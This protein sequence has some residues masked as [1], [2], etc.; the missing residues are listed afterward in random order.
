MWHLGYFIWNGQIR[1]FWYG[2]WEL[3]VTK[4]PALKA[5]EEKEVQAEGTASAKAPRQEQ[6]RHVEGAEIWAGVE[7]W[8]LA[9]EGCWVNQRPREASGFKL[10]TSLIF[11]FKRALWLPC[12]QQTWGRGEANTPYTQ[13]CIQM[14]LFSSSLSK[15]HNKGKRQST[16]T[17]TQQALKSQESSDNIISLRKSLLTPC[18]WTSQGIEVSGQSEVSGWAACILTAVTCSK[19]RLY[20]QPARE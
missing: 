11:V 7:K 6:V 9:T 17:S 5:P 13:P 19:P 18:C 8:V 3:N 12:G 16:G 4:E 10:G 15:R 1:P 14:C 2:K 20:P